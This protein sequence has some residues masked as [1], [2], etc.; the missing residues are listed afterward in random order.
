MAMKPAPYTEKLLFAKKMNT[1]DRE[2]VGRHGFPAPGTTRK[3]AG[4]NP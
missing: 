4:S 2:L 3:L 1:N